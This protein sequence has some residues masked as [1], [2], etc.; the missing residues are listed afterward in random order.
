MDDDRLYRRTDPPPEVV[1]P[2]AKSKPKSRSRRSKATRASKRRKVETAAE[3]SE[4]AGDDPGTKESNDDDDGFGGMKW[5]CLAVTLGDY[6]NIISSLRRS[7]DPNEKALHDRL[8]EE[9]LPIIQKRAEE[10][11]RKALRKLKELETLQKLASAKRSSRIATKME[12][13]KEEE[14]AAE[15]EKKR[16]VD[17]SMARK[18]E[19]KRRKME[20]VRIAP[21]LSQ[22]Y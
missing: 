8:I 14:E 7:K 6:E 13:R 18:E 4:G 22:P 19:E 2:K 5:E 21:Y 1:R 16:Q 9:V 10:Q 11:E 17:L 20:E 3:D 15:V 12:K